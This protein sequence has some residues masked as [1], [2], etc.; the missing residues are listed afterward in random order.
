MKIDSVDKEFTLLQYREFNFY[1]YVKT[2]L[3]GYM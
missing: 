1:C 2:S 3:V